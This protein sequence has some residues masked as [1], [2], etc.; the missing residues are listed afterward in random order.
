MFDKYFPTF[1][2]THDIFENTLSDQNVLAENKMKKE[3]K[4]M[5]TKINIKR[6][7]E[8]LSIKKNILYQ[9]KIH[10]GT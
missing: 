10:G 4:Q 5:Y 9:Y 6:S 7:T 3:K 2:N 1:K 8:D